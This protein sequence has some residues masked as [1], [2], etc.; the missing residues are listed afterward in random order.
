MKIEKADV[1][2]ARIR[3]RARQA[4]GGAA[5]TDG[6]GTLWSGDIGDDFY[7]ALLDRGL[8]RPRGHEAMARAA[9]EHGVDASGSASALGLRLWNEYRAGRYPELPFYELMA[10]CF[11]GF[12]REEA[13]ALARDVLVATKLRERLHAEVLTV[14][15]GLRADGVEVLLVSASPRAI[16]EAAAEIVGIAATN[17]IA[18]T[19]RH[20]TEG[21]MPDV[22][23]PIPYAA[24]KA[25]RLRDR[26]GARRLYAAFGDNAFDVAMLAG[27]DIGVAVR[28]KAAL[29]ARAG[30]VA[31]IVELATA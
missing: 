5:A 21:I 30:E 27:A 25:E 1:L 14:L 26:L 28:P 4:P 31:G 29:R 7:E 11:A 16:V 3:E 23:R 12:T 22:E 8:V 15:A 20:D 18:A 6:D 9:K 2:L 19:P 17:V 13:S 24:G 10:W